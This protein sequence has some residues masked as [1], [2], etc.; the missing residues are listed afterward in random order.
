MDDPPSRADSPVEP[1]RN[2]VIVA[3]ESETLGL[4]LG[5]CEYDVGAVVIGRPVMRR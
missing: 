4:I 3:L 5:P 2:S 1:D